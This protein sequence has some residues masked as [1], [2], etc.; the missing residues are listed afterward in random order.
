VIY[1]YDGRQETNE[2]L[3]KLEGIHRNPVAI[4][5][6][7]QLCDSII[8]VDKIG[9][10]EYWTGHKFDYKFPKNLHFE[11]KLDTDLFEFVKDKIIIHSLCLSPNG[12]LF[13]ALTSNKKVCMY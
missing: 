10:I 12:R 3:K 1:I 7:N 4:V 9:M 5:K 2:P 8:S 13:A 11:S 6:F